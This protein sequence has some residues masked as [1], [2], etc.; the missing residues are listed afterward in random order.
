[1]SAPGKVLVRVLLMLGLKRW[2][3]RM[4]SIWL[5]IYPFVECHVAV[6]DSLW[7]CRVLARVSWWLLANS[8]SLM[9]QSLVSPRPNR[10]TVPDQLSYASGPTF[11]F[12]S[13]CTSIIF[14]GDFHYYRLK[15]FIKLFNFFICVVRG[16]GI[17]LY[18]GHV[19]WLGRDSDGYDPAGDGC[20]AD[21]AA[22]DVFPYKE[23]HYMLVFLLFSREPQLMS[24]FCYLPKACESDFAQSD[25][26]PAL[27]LQCVD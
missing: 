13:P 26:I 6:L 25:N 15:L 19:V 22:L 5:W 10:P 17:D 27:V 24:I 2:G 21:D 16:W 1:M 7:G 20:A 14:F 18:D 9:P 4:K 11:A 23:G 3:A 8:R 12:Q